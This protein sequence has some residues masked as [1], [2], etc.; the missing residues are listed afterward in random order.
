M[1]SSLQPKLRGGGRRE[2]RR[3]GGTVEEPHCPGRRVISG[4]MSLW[5]CG[6]GLKNKR[7]ES[8]EDC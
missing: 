8:E 6:R 1:C 5:A 2:A 7:E 3:E 4:E